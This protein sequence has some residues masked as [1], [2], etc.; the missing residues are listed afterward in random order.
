M[1]IIS[2][3]AFK[4]GS[5]WLYRILCVMTGFAPLPEKYLNPEWRNPS[6]HP[7][8]LRDLLTELD[9]QKQNYICKNHFGK[10]IQ[11]DLI[12]SHS[13]IFVISIT[14]DIK[15][16]VVSAYYYFQRQENNTESFEEYYWSRGRKV[17]QSVINYNTL[18]DVSAANLYVTSY[19][20]LKNDFDLELINFANTLKIQIDQDK[21]ELIKQETQSQKKGGHFRKGIIG[22]WKNHFSHAMLR[23][24]NKIQ[25]KGINHFTKLDKLVAQLNFF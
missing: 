24:I 3:G 9:C 17:A 10:R 6:I 12:L 2:N 8:K 20:N 4:S 5:S 21:I 19:E 18:W 16:V 15:D 13:D 14:R 22:D 25:E 7:E 23:D 1:L 11:R